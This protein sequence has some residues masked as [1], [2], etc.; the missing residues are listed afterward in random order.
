MSIDDTAR[1]VDST[2]GDSQLREHVTVHDS[3]IGDDCRLYERVSVKKSTL[4]DS[5]DI[6]AGSYV[7]NATVESGVQIGP[8][9]TVAGVTHDLDESGMTFRNDSFEPIHLREGVFLGG[10]AVVGPGVEL[11]ENA[12]VAAG[13]TVTDDVDSEMIVLG[14]PPDQQVVSLSEWV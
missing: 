5:I 13:A 2:V 10:G 14:S 1:V 6:N 11:G 9:S 7:E 8:N 12:V 3:D 4:G